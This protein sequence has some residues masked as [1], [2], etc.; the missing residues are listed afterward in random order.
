MENT[1]IKFDFYC[2]LIRESLLKVHSCPDEIV[3]RLIDEYQDVIEAC[4]RGGA[5]AAP[6]K[7]LYSEWKVFHSE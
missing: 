5:A 6:A 7:L 3:A 1:V 2:N 4:W